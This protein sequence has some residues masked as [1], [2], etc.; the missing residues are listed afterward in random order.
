ME[1]E[2]ESNHS[3]NASIDVIRGYNCIQNVT[4]LDKVVT[5]EGLILDSS[6][7]SLLIKAVWLQCFTLRRCSFR[8]NGRVVVRFLGRHRRVYIEDEANH[9]LDFRIAIR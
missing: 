6:F 3:P 2:V 9:R 1:G 4:I 8:H 7:V 5:V